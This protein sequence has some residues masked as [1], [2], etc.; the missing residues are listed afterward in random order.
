MSAIEQSAPLGARPPR[1]GRP[2]RA[3]ADAAILTAT[4]E[5]LREQG[6]AGLSMDVLAQ[7]AGVGKATIYRRW[8]S[9]EDLISEAIFQCAE[10]VVA[11]DTGST[12]GDLIALMSKLQS[13]LG[14]SIGGQIFPRMVGEVW[15]ATPLGEA[16]A[17]A[18]I[19]PRRQLILDVLKRGAARGELRDGFD[20]ELVADTLSGAVIVRRMV[21]G[22]EADGPSDRIEKLVALV[23][24]GLSSRA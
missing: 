23:L 9:K 21:A 10:A 6:V 18:V 12:R 22:P 13:D 17:K 11:P 7:R 8:H 5:L 15:D 2:R 4:I 1:R 19:R 16:F 24:D 20:A 3:D 14:C